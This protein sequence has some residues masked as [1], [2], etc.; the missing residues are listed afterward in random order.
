MGREGIGRCGDSTG[1][2]L[3]PGAKTFPSKEAWRPE[4][5]RDPG[6]AQ[7]NAGPG[8]SLGAF[9]GGG[10]RPEWAGRRRCPA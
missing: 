8:L 9:V 6:G 4:V 7:W 10:A 2:K 5:S 3:R 1:G